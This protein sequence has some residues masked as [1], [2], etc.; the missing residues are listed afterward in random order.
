[1]LLFF[2]FFVTA[3]KMAITQNIVNFIESEKIIEVELTIEKGD[4]N[5][6]AK[7]FRDAPEKYTLSNIDV[8][9]GNLTFKNKKFKSVLLSIPVQPLFILNL[10][11]HLLPKT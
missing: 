9:S 11:L 1:M 4:N 7:L 10:K 6:F 2:S 3:Q 5:R 8:K